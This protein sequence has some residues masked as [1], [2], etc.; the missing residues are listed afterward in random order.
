MPQRIEVP[1]YGIVEFPDGMSDDQITQAIQSNLAQDQKMSAPTAAVKSFNAGAESVGHGL[2]Q[3]I[4]EDV[5]NNPYINTAADVLPPGFAN[6]AKEGL[7]YVTD[8]TGIS[9]DLKNAS[10]A[11]A[12]KRQN[13]YA[14]AEKQYPTL[15]PLMNIAGNIGASIP[16][17]AIPGSAGLK[18][19]EIAASPVAKFIQSK[20]AEVAPDSAFA[21]ELTKMMEKPPSTPL[22]KFLESKLGNAVTS[23]MAQGGAMGSSQYVDDD[24]SKILNTV[25]G[26]AAGAGIPFASEG[27]SRVAGKVYNAY[28]GTIADPIAKKVIDLGKKWNVPVFASDASQSPTLDA[29]SQALE[30]VPLLGIRGERSAQM[31]AAQNAAQKEVDTLHSQMGTTKFGGKTGMKKIQEAATIP[32]RRAK[33]AQD[34]LEEINNAGDDTGKVIQTSGNV[35]LFRAKMTADKK[36]NDVQNMA[37]KFGYVD[38]SKTA[39]TIDNMLNQLDQSV[40]KNKPLIAK[41][42]EIKSGLY[43]QVPAKKASTILDSYGNP[44]IPAEVSSKPVL[45]AFKFSQMRD[46]RS[47]LSDEISKYFQGENAAIGKKGVGYLQGLKDQV[48]GRLEDFAKSNGKDLSTLWHNADNFY[49]NYLIPAKDRTLAN[50][51]KNAEPDE[52]Y[53]KFITRGTK[54]G[55]A[56]KFYNSLDDK[57]KA[58]V[59]YGMASNAFEKAVNPENRTFSP[60]IFDSEIK[61]ISPSYGVFF[62]GKQKEETDGLLN[63]MRHVE[64]SKVALK[65]PET[66][67][68]VIPWLVGAATAGAASFAP[69]MT[70][71]SLASIY[72]LK[73]LMTT[74]VGRRILLAS[75]KFPPGS[76]QMEKLA[77]QARAVIQKG[78]IA[79]SGADTNK[80][81]GNSMQV[82]S[83]PED[84]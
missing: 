78:G 22:T 74:D 59:R 49:K 38:T 20:L 61:K 75:S 3:P 29:T 71:V 47:D 63:L 60:A 43:E 12:S 66:G 58:A 48:S 51:L 68:K 70:I 36:Y 28:K 81:I 72:G 83:M 54:P 11:E 7:S 34:L 23:G 76:P 33:G 30:E 26:I 64:R 56:T 45:K 25:L 65:K 10:R 35:N 50:A 67:V 62:R 24:G 1:N 13:D 53:G 2:L 32:G 37:D 80:D 82:P 19:E 6:L 57:G 79:L 41:L 9:E 44:V 21:K 42:N 14:E 39:S 84:Q 15:A 55:R 8:K 77:A 27:A 18:A 31:Q 73:K 40:L 5:A 17:M 4:L 46:F 16:A 52:V 69:V